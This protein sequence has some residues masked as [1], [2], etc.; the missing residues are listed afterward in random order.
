MDTTKLTLLVLG[1]YS[2]FMAGFFFIS[3]AVD[4]Y[5]F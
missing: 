4:Q 1:A 5:K 2:I 3:N